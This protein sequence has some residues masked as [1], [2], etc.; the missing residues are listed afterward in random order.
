M[1]S[2]EPEIQSCSKCGQ[3]IYVQ[4]SHKAPYKKYYTN[5]PKRS[6][7]HSKTCL[8]QQQIQSQ[9]VTPMIQSQPVPK[10][11]PANHPLIKQAEAKEKTISPPAVEFET[12]ESTL[13]H[14]RSFRITQIIV[15][16]EKKLTNETFKELG[17]YENRTYFISLTI[18]I[19]NPSSDLNR[20]V[21]EAYHQIDTMIELEIEQDRIK[22]INL[23]EEQLLL[24]P[25]R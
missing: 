11:D 21:R 10:R 14:D 8:G 4:T 1:A 20:R 22:L 6:D 9:K 25:N 2:N 15:S 24:H 18:T 12:A 23:R 7:F 13:I 17:Q 16:K 5:T 19:D 3:K